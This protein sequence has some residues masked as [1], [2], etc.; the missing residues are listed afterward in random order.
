LRF[1]GKAKEQ[2]FFSAIEAKKAVAFNEDYD[3]KI[4]SGLPILK[5][6]RSRRIDDESTA[7]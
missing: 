7:G 3:H 2:T 1:V 6:R 5:P 4:E